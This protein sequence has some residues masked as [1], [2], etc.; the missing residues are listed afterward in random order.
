MS[1]SS[2][3]HHVPR[4]LR[5]LLFVVR[6]LL[7]VTAYLFC[8][9]LFIVVASRS[10]SPLSAEASDEEEVFAVSIKCAQCS[11]GSLVVSVPASTT[12]HDLAVLAQAEA[13]K[14]GGRCGTSKA[15]SDTH[16]GQCTLRWT[17]ALRRVSARAERTAANSFA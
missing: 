7:Q 9:F 10:P 6:V 16:G 2:V 1:S 5:V 14:Q 13:Q 8:V 11:G 17:R 3:V 4:F 15:A 12:P